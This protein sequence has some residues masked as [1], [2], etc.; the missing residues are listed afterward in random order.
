MKTNLYFT[1]VSG[2]VFAEGTS[3]GSNIKLT[4]EPPEYKGPSGETVRLSCLVGED[5]GSYIIRW[6]RANGQE[7]PPDSVQGD[8]VLTI[9]D[10]SPADSDVYVCTVTSRS[11]GAVAEIQARVTV[12]S[13][14]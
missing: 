11:T 3:A 7:L 8:G 9:F 1:I 10:A 6:S 4:V 2:I 12:V 13:S 5:R 14:Q